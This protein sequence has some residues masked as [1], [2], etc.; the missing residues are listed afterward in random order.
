MTNTN[1]TLRKGL[2]I[3]Q[4]NREAKRKIQQTCNFS[5]FRGGGGEGGETE[6]KRRTPVLSLDPTQGVTRSSVGDLNGGVWETGSAC[7]V[8]IAAGL[9]GLEGGLESH[10]ADDLK[11]K[12]LCQNG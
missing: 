3:C 6:R 4:R 1:K 8:A 7:V 10:L 9:Y 12:T 2:Y 5:F 11:V